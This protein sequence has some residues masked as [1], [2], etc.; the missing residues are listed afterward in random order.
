MPAGRSAALRVQRQHQRALRTVASH[1]HGCAQRHGRS[2][3][4]GLRSEAVGRVRRRLVLRAPVP[5]GRRLRRTRSLRLRHGAGSTRGTCTSTARWCRF[6]WFW[7]DS[8]KNVAKRIYFNFVNIQ[9]NHSLTIR[10]TLCIA[11]N[12]KPDIIK[13]RLASAGPQAGQSEGQHFY[14]F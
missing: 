3:G 12:R 4:E 14:T 1:P 10:K 5:R 6:H 9:I 8:S 2:R 13:T 11:A 7:I